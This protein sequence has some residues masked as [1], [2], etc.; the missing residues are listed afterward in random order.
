MENRRI[1]HFL[2]GYSSTLTMG[3]YFPPTFWAFFELQRDTTQETVLFIITAFRTLNP[4]KGK[5]CLAL[6]L[7][8]RYEKTT[9]MDKGQER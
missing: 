9:H 1:R 4:G 5:E 8:A 7:N 3:L 2:L 6:H